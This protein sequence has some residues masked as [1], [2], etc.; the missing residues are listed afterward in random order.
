LLFVPAGLGGLV[1]DVRD[2][3]LRRLAK[4]KGI[5]VPSLLADVR[6][7]D[8][9]P[10]GEPPPPRPVSVPDDDA[11][12][13]VR[14]LE[15]SYG[16]TQV[17]FGVDMHVNRGEIVALLGTNGAGK[18]TLLSAVS[19]LLSPGAGSITFDGHELGRSA[20]TDRV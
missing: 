5:V 18:S 14:D 19:G 8:V 16:R 17:L 9:D 1:Y 2:R 11:I 13:V 20:P 15:V 4:G 10:S 6:V 7:D 3:L 12:L